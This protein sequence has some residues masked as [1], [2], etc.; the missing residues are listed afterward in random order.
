MGE[1][2]GLSDILKKRDLRK[3]FLQRRQVLSKQE[4][5]EKSL[6]IVSEI[7]T[8]DFYINADKIAIY[9]P[10]RGEVS[11]LGLLE[12][13]NKQIYFP[14]VRHDSKQLAF[15]RVETME[16]LKSGAYGIME[17]VDG[18]PETDISNIDL[19]LVPGVA[20]STKGERIGYGGGYYDATLPFKKTGKLA[21][22][23]AFDIQIAEAGFSEE[24]DILLDGL[25]TESFNI[26][27]TE[28]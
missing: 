4:I 16:Q 9:H 24:C 28:S 7:E 3:Y 1:A 14:K 21:I 22:G 15:F 20:F 10:F 8:C 18:L 27:L 2:L 5:N 6:K 25:V 17:P 13:G 12:K 11:L 26:I 19:F 23:I